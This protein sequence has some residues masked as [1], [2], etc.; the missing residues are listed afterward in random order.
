MIIQETI[1]N[2]IVHQYN[3]N[4]IIILTKYYTKH[5][6]ITHHIINMKQIDYYYVTNLFILSDSNLHLNMLLVFDS[7][8]FLETDNFDSDGR[9]FH[10]RAPV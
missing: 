5:N 1:T 10:K 4:I 3:T 9:L 2:L 6:N 8:I 7:K